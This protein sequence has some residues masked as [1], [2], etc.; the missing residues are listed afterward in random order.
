MRASDKHRS[1]HFHP[2]SKQSQTVLM[3]QAFRAQQHEKSLRI[4]VQMKG[5]LI[6]AGTHRLSL[7]LSNLEVGPWIVVPL[8]DRT[9]VLLSAARNTC[10]LKPSPSSQP[11]GKLYAYTEKRDTYEWD[12]AHLIPSFVNIIPVGQ[13][14]QGIC[15]SG[16]AR[17]LGQG[18]SILYIRPLHLHCI[19]LQPLCL[20]C[21]RET[22]RMLQRPQSRLLQEVKG[23]RLVH[24][25]GGGLD[26][27]KM[28]YRAPSIG[29]ACNGGS[30]GAF[31]KCETG[32]EE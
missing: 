25:D 13:P 32:L 30:R 17:E 14:T 27:P 28:A 15:V 5:Q 16:H 21:R 19:P 20:I 22:F 4:A 24:G 7:Y 1:S 18:M 31:E 2:R 12:V 23:T 10:P 8:I 29:P 26:R 3:T 9:T 6:A 11:K